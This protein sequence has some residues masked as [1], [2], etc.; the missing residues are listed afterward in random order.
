MDL[1]DLP[2]PSDNDSAITFNKDLPKGGSD[3]NKALYISV[4]A[5]GKPYKVNC[6]RLEASDFTPSDL[7]VRAYENTK[8]EVLGIMERMAVDALPVIVLLF[9]QYRWLLSFT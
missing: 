3:H 7:I 1:D 4:M 9:D 6:L 5:C 8:R 2:A